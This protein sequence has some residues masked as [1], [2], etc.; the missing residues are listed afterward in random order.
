MIRVL[1]A[2]RD[3]PPPAFS[4]GGFWEA[5][6]DDMRGYYEIRVD[7]TGAD[8]AQRDHYRLFCILEQNDPVRELGAPSL[9]VITGAV[10]P[11]Q[12]TFTKQ[13]YAAVRRLGDEYMRRTPR[14]VER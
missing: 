14:S 6:H 9:V 2:V 13:E 5:M 10:K 1:E 12:T 7:G 4:G 8:G 3:A 11:F